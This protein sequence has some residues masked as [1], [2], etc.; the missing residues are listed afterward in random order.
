MITKVLSSD[1]CSISLGFLEDLGVEARMGV[2]GFLAGVCG[3]DDISGVWEQHLEFRVL[4]GLNMESKEWELCSEGK[5]PELKFGR[6]HE[7]QYQDTLCR[8]L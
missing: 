2:G 8:A 4:K 7:M 5:S 1:L 6:P 3:L